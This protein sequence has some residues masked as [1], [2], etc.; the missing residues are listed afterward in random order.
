[1]VAAMTDRIVAFVCAVIFG[2]QLPSCIEQQQQSPA[3]AAHAQDRR[4][5]EIVCRSLVEARLV[6]SCAI[7]PEGK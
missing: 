6:K 7:A 2:A 1:M 3:L 5:L 4:T